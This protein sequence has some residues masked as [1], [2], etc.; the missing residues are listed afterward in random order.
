MDIRRGLM[1]I[2]TT[3][4][5]HLPVVAPCFLNNLERFVAHRSGWEINGIITVFLGHH[6]LGPAERLDWK[7][8]TLA[9][10]SLWHLVGDDFKDQRLL[11]HVCP[12]RSTDNWHLCY[13]LG[14]ADKDS[15]TV[16]FL[17]NDSLHNGHLDYLASISEDA[18]HF[19]RMARS[20][21]QVV[22]EI[23]IN[24]W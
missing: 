17:Q 4:R 15:G 23:E 13:R 3:G 6:M 21:G 5:D 20:E 10:Q 19:F 18:D 8:T 2:A 7:Q 16:V 1:L 14:A 12:R 11:Q 22:E 24:K 9:E